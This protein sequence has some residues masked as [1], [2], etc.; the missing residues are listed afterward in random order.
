M[1]HVYSEID[2][3]TTFKVYL[4]LAER[5][6]TAVGHK[7]KGPVQGGTETILLAEDDTGVRNLSKIILEKAGYTVL[8]AVD[9]EEALRVFKDHADEIDLALLDVIMPK[10]GG[11]AVFNHILEQRPDIRVLFSSGYSMNAVHTDFVLDQGLQLIQKPYQRDDLLQRVRDALNA[12]A[13]GM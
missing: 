13:S 1:V 9:G 6:A 8:A 2:K 12:D 11:R 4:V 10:L 5:A 3:G 7:I